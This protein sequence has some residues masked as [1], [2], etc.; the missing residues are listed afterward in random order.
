MSTT[1]AF[2]TASV[3]GT[4]AAFT[5]NDNI[6]AE[7]G[8]FA[9]AILNPTESTK[10]LVL[11]ELAT[12]IASDQTVTGFLV[13]LKS[14]AAG[15]VVQVG[16][17]QPRKGAIL[18]P[19]MAAMEAVPTVLGW[20]E[21]GGPGYMC[22]TSWTPAEANAIAVALWFVNVNQEVTADLFEADMAE[23][24]VYHHTTEAPTTATSAGPL[25]RGHRGFESA[26]YRH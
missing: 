22:S 1:S 8:V 24:V 16:F 3:E 20:L 9:T 13:R 25:S 7:D 23:L 18:C 21:W 10:I 17:L 6:L 12:E 14:R 26:R 5:D 2:T 4:G 11:S 15:G 19:N